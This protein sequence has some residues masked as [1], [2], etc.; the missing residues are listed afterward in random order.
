MSESEYTSL[1]ISR[2]VKSSLDQYR[3]EKFGTDSVS[4][5]AT[6]ES[7]LADAQGDSEGGESR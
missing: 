3:Q 2:E 5:V 6:I 7:L 1:H 4:Y